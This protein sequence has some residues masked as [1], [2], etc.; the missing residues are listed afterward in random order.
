MTTSFSVN[1]LEF[2]SNLPGRDSGALGRLPVNEAFLKIQEVAF[3]KKRESFQALSEWPALLLDPTSS[4]MNHLSRAMR[5]LSPK[6]LFTTLEPQWPQ[7]GPEQLFSRRFAITFESPLHS[8][9]ESPSDSSQGG[10]QESFSVDH[11][12]L[13]LPHSKN[14]DVQVIDFPSI[15][16]NMKE[17][18]E[19]DVMI[20]ADILDLW[21]RVS[22]VARDAFKR[23]DGALIRQMLFLYPDSFNIE[24]EPLKKEGAEVLDSLVGECPL[25]ASKRDAASQKEP[26]F[27]ITAFLA[28]LSMK[29]FDSNTLFQP[30]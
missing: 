30:L 15:G 2:P 14:V 24:K 17:S 8:T 13:S 19:E 5:G 28:L 22:T 3:H 1:A 4:K 9:A 27:T 20:R 10:L 29:N 25:V 21:H 23:K 12:P 11:P 18:F 7:R 26:F 16:M 6:P